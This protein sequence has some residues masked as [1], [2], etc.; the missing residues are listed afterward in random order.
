M[1]LKCL[2]R[3]EICN[4]SKHDVAADVTFSPPQSAYKV[5]MTGSGP[6]QWLRSNA[7]GDIV[8]GSMG[9]RKRVAVTLIC[10]QE[11]NEDAATLARVVSTFGTTKVT[12]IWISD[13]A[14]RRERKRLRKL[15]S[16][17]T[18]VKKHS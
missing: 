8:V 10:S 7:D 5:F 9:P 12:P 17:A 3:L 16:T 14:T 6:L 4:W 1:Y 13:K 2:W 11:L 15:Q 18:A